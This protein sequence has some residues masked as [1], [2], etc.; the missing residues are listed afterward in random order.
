MDRWAPLLD[1]S[2]LSMS[3][4]NAGGSPDLLVQV[5]QVQQVQQVEQVPLSQQTGSSSDE[6]LP[7]SPS[8][9][10]CPSSPSSSIDSHSG[11]YSLVD[12][13][14]SPEAELNTAWMVSAQRQT[15]LATLKEERGFKLQTYA[16]SRKPRSL[17][18]EVGGGHAGHQM[19]LKAGVEAVLQEEDRLLRQEIIR[20]Q[21]PRK[22]AGPAAGV[23]GPDLDLGSSRLLDGFSL[24]FSPVRSRPESLAP[25]AAG[26]V[27]K[28]QINF[29]A[30]RQ[31]FLRL[32]Q[33]NRQ[34]DLL[35]SLK[36]SRTRPS[37][38]PAPDVASSE[39][40]EV[41]VQL[42]QDTAGPKQ[43]DLQ[44]KGSSA[45]EE[46]TVT[47]TTSQKRPN[48]GLRSSRSTGDE[49]TPIQREIRLVQD[50]E[51]KLR[52]SRGLK[53]SDDRA[54][55]VQ[56]TSKRLNLLTSMVP[57][58]QEVQTGSENQRGDRGI[59]R[60]Y[61]LE[62]PQK[63]EDQV[64]VGT[65]GEGTGP[66][67]RDRFSSPCC[68][69]R[70]SEETELL[71]SQRSSAAPAFSA[72][73]SG[74]LE[75][76]SVYQDRLTSPFSHVLLLSPPSSPGSWRES[77]ESSRLQSRGRGT[78]DFI[79]KEIEESLRREQELQELRVSRAQLRSFTP[80]PLV[81][82]DSRV[83]I[84]HLDPP[85]PAEIRAVSPPSGRAATRRPPSS[86]TQT[87][88]S[89][90]PSPSSSSYPS[91]FPSP[92]PSP[93]TSPSLPPVAVRA[94]P[95]VVG[96]LTGT[97]LQDYQA[98]QAQLRL[99]ESSYA[100]ILPVDDVNNEVVESTRVIRHKNQRALRWEARN[101]VNL[102][103]P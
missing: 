35:D 58:Q 87:R 49:E 63:L 102:E 97:L 88:A 83:A 22:R 47:Q 7:S 95:P 59:L 13:P 79:Q 90:P 4:Q 23:G 62:S 71:L 77:L 91:P 101:F 80:G 84:S 40:Q 74:V 100:G 51:E 39:Q 43:T 69:H 20:S 12:D 78:S 41:Q 56:I 37:T 81:E 1:F 99:E 42:S 10:S 34:P 17:F 15:Q 73:S 11:F 5:Q 53:P 72:T 6:W 32:E 18:P 57:V 82:Q 44:R 98:R 24:S 8:S 67:W 68:P 89:P 3:S 93:V 61:S 38:G 55:M 103:D 19:E 85:G 45:S 27:D 46:L 30:A 36:P 96:G 66:E 29:S 21:A 54:E 64:D 48:A 14:S 76:T 33:Q 26:A 31:Q 75:T 25:P 50:R 94:A 2:S 28:E 92:L 86:F 9:P 16:S 65:R 52:H 70:H 60:H